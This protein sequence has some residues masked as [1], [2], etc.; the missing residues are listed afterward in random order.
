MT[1]RPVGADAPLRRNL[2]VWG[3]GGVV[4]PFLG[5]KLIDVALTALGLA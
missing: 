4:A 1:Y 3:L 5:I 2:L